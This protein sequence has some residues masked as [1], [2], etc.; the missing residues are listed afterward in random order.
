MAT[1]VLLKFASRRLARISGRGRAVILK[2]HRILESADFMRPGE[3][4]AEEFDAQM[5]VLSTTFPCETFGGLIEKR[6]LGRHQHAAVVI[7][8]DDGYK[9]NFEFAL[10]I[11]RNYGLTATIF[12]STGFI[13]NGMM[14]NDRVIEAMRSTVGRSLDLGKAGLGQLRV[15]TMEEASRS[16]QQVLSTIKRWPQERRSRF[17]DELAMSTGFEPQS[18]LMMSE[19]EITALAAADMEIGAHTVTHPILS[20]LSPEAAEAEISLCK[21]E[22]ERLVGRAVRSFAYPNG[23]AGTDFTGADVERVRAAGYTGAVTTDWGCATPDSDNYRI[24]RQSIWGP[25]RLK[26][27]YRL[28]RNIMD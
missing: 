1:S 9:D 26:I 21:S 14:W 19:Q 23:R 7:T 4:T 28:M 27:W 22:L 11:L 17:V 3:T 10:P 12:V 13:G 24:P 2:Y 6:N 18:R 25:N 16:A 5:R 15:A 20:T 8:F